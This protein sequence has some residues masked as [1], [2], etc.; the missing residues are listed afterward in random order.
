M[1]GRPPTPTPVLKDRGTYRADRQG[2]GAESDGERPDCP[3]TLK[4][5]AKKEWTRMIRRLEAMRILDSQDRQYLFLWSLFEGRIDANIRRSAALEKKLEAAKPA[6]AE[7]LSKQL[8]RLD[9]EL[10][11]LVGHQVKIGDR[12][13]VGPC[14]RARAKVDRSEPQ[15]AGPR[16]S[17]FRLA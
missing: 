1:R 9:V 7:E 4:G 8:W 16:L 14:L 17:D 13:G 11:R 12:L 6:E 3:S 2:G 10:G 15:Q 5:E